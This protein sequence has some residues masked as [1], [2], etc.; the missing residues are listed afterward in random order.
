MYFGEIEREAA[1]QLIALALAEDLG[2]SFDLT[3]EALIAPNQFGSVEIVARSSGVLAGLPVAEMV[4][5]AVDA[6]LQFGSQAADGESLAPG[7]VVGAVSG[8]VRS[9]LVAERTCLNFLTHLSGVATLTR[10]YVEA[11]AG[12]H[13]DIYDTRK[14]LP[15]WRALQKY[16]VTA[17][18]G[19]NHRMGLYD[20]VLIKDNH[21]AGWRAASGDRS[22]AAA[23]RAAQKRAPAGTDIEIEVDTLEQ[24]ADALAGEPDIVLL[25]NMT[26]DQMREAVS[27]RNEQAPGVELEASG[28]VSLETVAAIAATGVERISVGALTHS[29]PALDLAFDWRRASR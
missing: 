20:M 14:T 1:A 13:A 22:L 4:L 29:A 2:P 27:L 7:R 28:G 18:G 9:L 11:I 12:S 26:L 24:L 10:R 15:G 25:D 19:K 21:L 6:D 5:A 23:V 16:A 17:G 8:P 3:T